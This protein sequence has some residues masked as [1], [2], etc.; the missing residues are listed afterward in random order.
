MNSELLYTPKY[1]KLQM[2]E[3]ELKCGYFPQSVNQVI[4]EIYTEL[5]I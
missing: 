5:K 2:N 1:A 3:S 4:E